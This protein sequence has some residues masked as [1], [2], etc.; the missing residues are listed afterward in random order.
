MIRNGL[1]PSIFLWTLWSVTIIMLFL[2]FFGAITTSYLWI[3]APISLLVITLL[4]V[5]ALAKLGY[6]ISV[7]IINIR[8]K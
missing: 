8:R 5:A 4:G 2:R 7:W 3:L 6:I 1:N